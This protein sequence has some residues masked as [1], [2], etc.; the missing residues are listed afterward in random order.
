MKEENTTPSKIEI[1]T[2]FHSFSKQGLFERCIECDKFL[3]D[4]GTEYFIEKAIKKYPGYK[5][6]D[7]I[8]EYA[9]CATCAEKMRKRISKESMKS[10]EKYFAEN[11]DV[12]QRMN[13]MQANPDNP[14]AWMKECMVKG[15][16]KTELN[17]FQI[18]AHC[19]GKHLEMTQMPYLI[20]GQ[21]LDEIAN[22]LSEK[23]L[24]ELDG[25]VNRH[26][27]PPPELMEPIPKKRL[28]L[29]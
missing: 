1:P 17:E 4:Q 24:D 2:D 20:S 29:I 3:L 10:I 21:A 18:Y 25:F 7:V 6:F 22:L 13:V 5:A 16:D 11:V 14:Q 26:F 23:T 27:G 15:S 8:F 12:N 28:V 19:N 9:I